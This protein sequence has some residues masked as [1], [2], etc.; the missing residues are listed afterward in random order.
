MTYRVVIEPSAQ[1]QARELAKWWKA[2]RRSSRTTVKKSLR[3]VAKELEELPHRYAE[4]VDREVRRRRHR[5]TP[6][7]AFYEVDEEAT[8]VRIVAVWSL[9]RGDGPPL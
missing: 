5:G 2:N 3:E 6:Y 7:Y 8:E 1:A 9:M 4:Y